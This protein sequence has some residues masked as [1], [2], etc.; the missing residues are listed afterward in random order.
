MKFPQADIA[1]LWQASAP[2]PPEPQRLAGSRQAEIAVIGGGYTGLSTARALARQGVDVVVLEA[3]RLGW[4]ASGR[5]G[6]VVSGKFRISY[7]RMARLWG[8]DVARRMHGIGVAAMENVADLLDEYDID[9]QYRPSGSLR[10]AHRPEALSAL[11]EEC[12]WLRD[13]LGDRSV[14]MLDATEMHDEIGAKG[15]CGGML[16]LRGG[17]IHPLRFHRGLAAGLRADGVAIHDESPVT[18]IEHLRGGGLNLHLPQGQLRVQ[19]AV[20]ATNAYSSL[21]PAGDAIRRRV[22]PFRSAMI[23]TGPLTGLSGATLLG[24]GRSYTE[25]RRMMRWFRM[26]GD[27]LL[28]GGRGAFGQRDRASAFA[29]LE[30]ALLRQFPQL[31][32]QEITHRWS[33]LVA[34]TMDSLPHVGRLDDRLVYAMGY[35]GTGVA[36]ASYMGRHVAATVLNQPDDAGLITGLGLRNVPFYPAREIGV[37][38]VAGWYQALDALGK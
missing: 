35:N 25:T 8:L 17:V 20:L 6:G 13:V 37:R 29:A 4:G 23:A 16:N 15:F 36:M 28:Y 2:P 33:G 18:A 14:S 7:A 27:R 38:L 34:M 31:E 1:S 10:C 12:V 11:R 9:A 22:V 24:N 21:T 5:N 3:N 32:G 30:R 26:S 19:Q